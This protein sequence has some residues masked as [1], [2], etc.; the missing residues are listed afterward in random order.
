MMPSENSSH[1][2]ADPMAKKSFKDMTPDEKRAYKRNTY[3]KNKELYN[4]AKIAIGLTSKSR[5]VRGQTVEKY[6]LSKNDKGQYV[7]PRKSRVQLDY[8]NVE[9]DPP[10]PIINVVIKNENSDIK[11]Y[12]F[13]NNLCN[14]KEL[15][16][17]VAT[18]LSKSPKSMM[19]DDV[20][21]KAEI[22][23]YLSIP[24]LLFQLHNIPY[25]ENKDLSGWIKDTN[26][27]I[28]RIENK[29]SWRAYGTKAKLLGRLLLLIKQFPPLK[30]RIP[31]DV[32]TIYDATYNK[33]EGLS[34]AKQ[35]L[36]TKETPIFSWNII[37]SEVKKHYGKISYQNLLIS[38]YDEMIGR[39]D[40][41]LNMA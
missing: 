33:W 20:R 16:N 13:D 8:D 36:H 11:Q 5:K 23:K 3:H 30:H 9:I 2:I 35:R 19:G 32:Y 1:N 7:L 34:K 29:E 24:N 4:L 37:Q 39:D 41:Q 25:D 15:K 21:G 38:L 12:D 26:D 27:L 40:F 17:W 28:T 14:G 31:K 6:N 22:K 18:V 10:P